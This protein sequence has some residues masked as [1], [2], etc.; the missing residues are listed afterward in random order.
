MS[1]GA[2]DVGETFKQ[3]IEACRNE[4]WREGY[5]LLTRVAQEAER[6]G[7]LP[8]VFYSTL[9][10]AMARC[11]GRKGD[12]LELCRFGVQKQPKEAENYYN[13]ATMYLMVGRRAAAVR[14]LEKGL[15]LRPGHLRLREL[16]HSLGVRRRPVFSF[17]SRSNPVNVMAG[18]ARSW[19]AERREALRAHGAEA[20]ERRS[21][22]ERRKEQ[23]GRS[24]ATI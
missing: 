14:A 4:K 8:G 1:Q 5:N 13:L 2:F 11:E 18:M 23:E 7:N 15:R 12:G 6:G 3:G 10:L 19:W 21:D 20:R 16:Q 9:G 17:P 24:G 22:A